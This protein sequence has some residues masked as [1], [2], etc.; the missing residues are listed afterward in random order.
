MD[1]FDYVIVG[2]GSAGCV[3]A[4]R[5]TEDAATR[6]CVLEAGPAD[7]HP[8][9]H[10]PAGFIKTFYD[11]RVNWCQHLR[12]ARQDAR[13][14]V[15]DQ[16]P[17]LQ[18]WPAPGLRHLG[19][20]GQPRLGLSRRAAVFPPAG[21]AHR[22]R[23]CNLPRPRRRPDGDRHRLAPSAVRG[24]HRRRAQLRHPAQPGLQRH[25]PGGRRL[26]PAHHPPR[27]PG[28]RRDVVPAPGDEAP[29]PRGAHPRACHRDRARGQARG[30]R[31]LRQGR[32]RRRHGRGARG[33]GGAAR[34]RHLQLAAAPAALGH[35]P[36]AAAAVARHPG[37]A[38][39]RRRWRRAAGPLRAA[40]G[41][42]GQEH[43]LDQRARARP[44]PDARGAQV[45]DHAARRARAVA[46]PGLLLLAFRRDRRELR[47]AA[48]L[49]AGELQG[50]RDG[51]ARGRARHDLR[52]LAAAPGEPR[53][54]PCP[55]E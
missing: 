47:P 13:R 43:H 39:A 17:H 49:H 30:R 21:A 14:L 26:R 27:P 10:L 53:L 9:I 31:A 28:Q 7:W 32:S 15:L 51:Q 50:R 29:Q 45:G 42:A 12:A 35:R 55:V 11:T 20:D 41:G 23:R 8:Y 16:R 25:H 3:L 6:V 48:H 4:N 22:R 18:P 54:C 19:T 38:R 5:L 34:R 1:S 37:Q 44:Q 2:A 36:G 40:L 33:Q 24:L 46:D 52:G